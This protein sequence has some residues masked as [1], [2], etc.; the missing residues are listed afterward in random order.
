VTLFLKAKGSG[1]ETR[2]STG[3]IR[4]IVQRVQIVF[5]LVGHLID[6]E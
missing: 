6:L 3:F 5:L 1:A 4:V 2:Q